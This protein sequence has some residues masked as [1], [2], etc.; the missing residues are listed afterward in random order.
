VLIPERLP[1]EETARALT[2][3]DE[4]GVRVGAVVV[5][6]VLPATSSDAF[7]TSR[8]NQERIYLDEIAMRFAEHARLHI[9]QLESDVYG[10]HALQRVSRFLVGAGEEIPEK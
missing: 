9:P 7:L 1:I 6:R 8:R 10:L 3:L 2:L 5:N 4:A